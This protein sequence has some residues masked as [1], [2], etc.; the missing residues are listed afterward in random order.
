VEDVLREQWPSHVMR[1]CVGENT[2]ELLLAKKA[3][4]YVVHVPE[5]AK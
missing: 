2:R 5:L 4:G 1:G 3:E